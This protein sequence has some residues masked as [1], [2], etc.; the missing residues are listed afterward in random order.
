[1]YSLL[2]LG[3]FLIFLALDPNLRVLRV[4]AS[5]NGWGDAVMIR[6]VFEFQP[7]DSDKILVS[8]DYL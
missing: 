1:M 2:T 3:A 6:H 7:N 8:L 4:S 5:L